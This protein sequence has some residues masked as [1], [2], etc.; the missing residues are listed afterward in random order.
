MRRLLLALV[1]ACVEAQEQ[2]MVDG[3]CSHTDHAICDDKPHFLSTVQQMNMLPEL[4]KMQCSMMGAWG[5][6]TPD[7]K[8]VQLRTLDFGGGPFGHE[9]LLVVHHPSGGASTTAPS[10]AAVSFPGFVGVVTGFSEKVGLSEKVD[11]VTH[12]H[13][14]KGSFDG[15]PV[16]LVIRE[17]L[18]FSTSKEDAVKIAQKAQ[19]TWSVWLGVG[20]YASQEFTA[21]LYD[22]AA[23]VPYSDKSITNVTDEPVYPGVVYIDKHPH[24][25]T[26][27]TQPCRS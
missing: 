11:D 12:S 7:G 3:V 9:T 21:M 5:P 15:T 13:R 8:L 14:P 27:R 2:G 18:E 1:V 17:M 26:T 10:F 22:Q 4:L 6:S 25:Q 23:V 19:R 16:A 20:D 24:H